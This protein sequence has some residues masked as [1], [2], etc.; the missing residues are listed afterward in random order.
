MLSI[1]ATRASKRVL[2]EISSRVAAFEQY[3]SMA[4]AVSRAAMRS[5]RLASVRDEG[6]SDVGEG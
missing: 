6:A 5:R 1:A 4:R 2:A 3:F